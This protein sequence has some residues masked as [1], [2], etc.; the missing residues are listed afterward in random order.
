MHHWRN[1]I[2]QEGHRRFIASQRPDRRA[3]RPLQSGLS[4]SNAL[5]LSPC[6]A[7]RYTACMPNWDANYAYGEF[8]KHRKLIE[9]SKETNEA[10]TRL[11]AID[12]MLFAVL[13][14]DRLQVDAETHV[15][16]K[17]YADYVLRHGAVTIGVVEAKRDGE[18]FV[19]SGLT[20][21]SEPVGFGLLA[22]ESKH[23]R[24]A[25]IQAASYASSLGSMYVAISNGHQYIITLAYVSRVSIEQRSVM[26]FESLDAIDSRFRDFY[27]SLSP[28]GVQANTLATK[29]IES[30]R[31]PAP[32]KLSAAIQG[33]PRSADRNVIANEIGWVLSTVW[34]KAHE[35]D[36]GDDFL[37][38]CYVTP[39]ASRG[40]L[41]Q[42]KEIIEQ[43]ARLDETAD[44][45]QVH[46]Q[47]DAL[48]IVNAPRPEKPIIVLGRVGHGKSTFLRY[49]RLVEAKEQLAG[50]IQIEVDFLHRPNTAAE[51]QGHVFHTFDQ[52]MLNPYEIDIHEADFARA[53]LDSELRRFRR[54]VSGSR[55][56]AGSEAQR[57]VEDDFVEAY[58][59][60]KHKYLTAVVRHLRRSHHKSLA[61]FFD[62]LDRQDDAIQERAFFEA[63]ALARDW[64]ALVFVCLR[65]GTFYKSAAT[66]G[67]DAIAP[68]T[69]GIAPPR[70]DIVLRKRFEFAREVAAGSASRGNGLPTVSFGK[71]ISA[72][73]PTAAK[74]FAC[75]RDS[76]AQSR[77]LTAVFSAVANGDMRLLLRFVRDFLTSQ[78]LNT[79]KIL[80]KIDGDGYLLAPHEAVRALLY[81]DYLHY[82]PNASVFPNLFDTEHADG[83]EHFVR[84]LSLHYLARQSETSL[85]HGFVQTRDVIDYL[86]QLGFGQGTAQSAIASLLKA[87]CME[88]RFGEHGLTPLQDNLRITPL[89]KFAVAELLGTFAYID[90]VVV[91]TPVTD[92]I[93]R[94]AIKD[95]GNIEARIQRGRVFKR[96]LDGCASAIRDADAAAFW[97]AVSDSLDVDIN[98]VAASA[99]SRR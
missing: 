38:R 28:T 24:D 33:Y 81:G 69:I 84:P 50:Y 87:K 83:L 58:Q 22:K 75:C 62:N 78:H 55:N 11:R 25:M 99:S 95:E 42:A 59:E 97:K 41:A 67:L 68:R 36:V 90:A 21:S 82:D 26:V 80:E 15:R 65:P 53:A 51:V 61:V 47:S 13:G 1:S 57:R 10:T 9:A 93:A 74:F 8:V 70:P 56:A 31:A 77:G 76:F 73:L 98:R 54:T 45:A 64:E 35:N 4:I 18:S 20:H 85:N 32:A 23:A 3:P 19:L 12:T 88:D 46:P 92:A 5:A 94:A 29:L 91:D 89:G 48:D 7:V 16:A 39:E 86:C 43:R 27:D 60:Q 71:N 52:Q 30:R 72:E 63:S 79:Q 37:R 34:D 17:G 66:G 44:E 14:W 96:Y 40:M 6:A 2:W 49:L